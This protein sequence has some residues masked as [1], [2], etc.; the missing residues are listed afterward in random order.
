MLA[1]VRGRSRWTEMCPRTPLSAFPIS[2]S[3]VSPPPGFGALDVGPWINSPSDPASGVV[4]LFSSKPVNLG[5]RSRRGSSSQKPS[6]WRSARCSARSTALCAA[7]EIFFPSQNLLPRAPK[8]SPTPTQICRG[9][10]PVRFGKL[11]TIPKWTFSKQATL[12][13]RVRPGQDVPRWRNAP[14][15]PCQRRPA[16]ASSIS[17][18]SAAAPASWWRAASRKIRP[19]VRLSSWSAIGPLVR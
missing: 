2:R 1:V 19:A 4:L 7:A 14:P 16:L 11:V 15:V 18:Q 8:C 3:C 12:A 6:T 10:D 9:D 13:R 17:I 5:V